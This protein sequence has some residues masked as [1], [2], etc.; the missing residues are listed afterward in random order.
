M[1]NFSDKKKRISYI[2]SITNHWQ[3]YALLAI[4]LVLV[5]VF[6]YVPMYGILIA[7]KDYKVK[8]GILGSN[9]VGLKYFKQ[10]FSS[11]TSG[12]TIRHTITISLY[13]I[14]AS[15]PFPIILALMLNYCRSK[16]LKN[17][18]Q[19]LT[20]A[21]YFISTV[22][23]VALLNTFLDPRSG[24]INQFIQL[25]G[26]KAQP[27]ISIGKLFPHFYVWSGIWQGTGYSAVIYI[28]ALSSIPVEL[29][30]SAKVDG[31]TKI[32]QILFIDIPYMLPTAMIMLILNFGQLMNVGFEKVY[33]MQN[34]ANITISEVISTYV[35]KI[36][37]INMDMSFSTAIN[38]FNSVINM[39]MILLVNHI[40]SKIG[41][42]TLF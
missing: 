33:L 4:P 8:K 11:A 23:L 14:I 25:L 15:F 17:L 31:I 38:L 40:A 22:V 41:D 6:N 32:Q 24:I 42:T 18:T 3:L 7:F 9:W 5:I 39:C 26:F 28:S 30:E 21:P 12:A 20:Y 29:Y 1:K 34:P 27:F 37:L 16:R 36:G 10:F 2:K 35:Y 19:M 13:S